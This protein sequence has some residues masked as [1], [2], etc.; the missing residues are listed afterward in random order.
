MGKGHY[1]YTILDA[2]T[3]ETLGSM[4]STEG[5]TNV[6]PE[7]VR[8]AFFI[9]K[10]SDLRIVKVEWLDYDEIELHV[11][12]TARELPPRLSVWD[13]RN[14]K[15]TKSAG[16]PTSIDKLALKEM[17]PDCHHKSLRI[18]HVDLGDEDEV[19]VWVKARKR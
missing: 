19:R 15:R 18:T 2:R 4:Q 3:G 17:F 7:M 10:S 16:N 6:T 5:F 11:D 13:S 8:D 1:R 12:I 9:F 14:G